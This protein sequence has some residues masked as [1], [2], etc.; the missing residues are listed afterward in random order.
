MLLWPLTGNSQNIQFH[1][2]NQ[3]F[4]I[5]IRET[6]EVCSDY[7]GFIWVSSKLGIIRLTEEDYR[8]YLL[9]Y[10][11]G[12]VINVKLVYRNMKLYAYTN[13]GQIF[14]YDP[15]YDRF[16]L[17][18][19]MS[20]E[21]NNQYLS[22]NTILL[23][24]FNVLWIATSDGLYRY[25]KGQLSLDENHS[26]EV[27]FIEWYGNDKI[28]IAEDSGLIIY[29]LLTADDESVCSKKSSENFTVCKLF[30]DQDSNRLW[31]GTLFS[32]LFYLD[33]GTEPKSIV[34]VPE[35][36]R[37]PI[38]A[39]EPVSDNTI[40]VGI[41]GQGIWEIDSETGEII[42]S[43]KENPDDPSSL[44]GNGVYDIYCDQNRRVWVCTYSGG[45]SFFDQK[46]P[47]I[48]QYRHLI[49]N[50]NSLVNNDVNYVLED[51]EGKLWFATNNGISCY[52]SALNIWRTYNHNKMERAQVFTN[53]CE[54]DGKI[55][56][57]TYSS[58]VYLLDRKTGKELAHYFTSEPGSGGVSNFVFS[59]YKDDEGDIWIGGVQGNLACFLQKEGIF[60]S[61]AYLP[62]NVLNESEP[63]KI[64]AGCTY[65]LVQIDKV[66]GETENLVEGY[67]V[68]DVLV[69]GEYIWLCTSGDGLIR[70]NPL[71]GEIKKFT[72]DDGLLSDFVNSA[73]Y[74][75]GY[76]WLG[77]ESG[78]CRLD[79]GSGSVVIFPS[80]LTLSNISF[81][82]NAHFILKNGDLIWGTNNGA[83]QFNPELIQDIRPVGK[84]FFQDVII[85]GSSL[86]DIPDFKPDSPLDS[87]VE[88]S[89]RHNQNTI[90][91]ELLSLG[92]STMGS[93]FSWQ[94]EG[95][96][97]SW[98][99][100]SN[101]RTISYANL[102]S[103]DF[104]LKIRMY[105]SALSQILD[106]REIFL[107]I[108]PPFW[109]KVW[110]KIGLLL[111][112][113]GIIGFAFTE[114]ISRLNKHHADQK[115]RFFSQMAHDMRTSVTLINSPVEELNKETKLSDTGRYFLNLA[116]E[117][118][119]RLASVV[120]QLMDFQK[121]DIGK[122]ILSLAMTDIVRVIQ[123]R[124]LMFQ[125]LAE[126]NNIKLNFKSNRSKYL[127]AI[128]EGKIEKVTDNL[129]SNAIKYSKPDSEVTIEI[130]C[131]ESR[132][133]LRVE[134]RGIGISRKSQRKMFNEFYRGENA[135]NAKIVGSGIGL[136][137]ARNYVVLH[138]GKISC[139]SQENVGSV[140]QVV[141]P[142]KKVK[143]DREAE[144]TERKDESASE[145]V[146]LE[147]SEPD[148]FEELNGE[149]YKILVVDDH[150]ELRNYMKTTLGQD[151]TV[152]TAGDGNEGWKSVL[153][154]APDIVISDIIMFGMD[155][156]ELCRILKS[157]YDT[158]HIPV[159]LLTSL[160]GKAEELHGLGLGADDYLTKPFDIKLL[161]QKIKTIIHNRSV[162]RE[163]ALK[164]IR[165]DDR[166]PVLANELNDRFVK[167]MVEVV[168]M[169]ISNPEF[170][171]E[172]FA[173]E[174][175]VSSSL[176]YK[177]AKSLTDQSPTD[178]LKA[179][180]M[181]HALRLIKE[182]KYN[183]TEISIMCGFSSV[184]YFSTVFKN[185]YRKSPSEVLDS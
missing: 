104:I 86:R 27:Q 44:Q 170:G 134:D 77:T 3:K 71:T 54:D 143:D 183:I 155:G 41:D 174:M 70:F 40:M 154:H 124:V 37:Q 51:K 125:Y 120:T 72:V 128:D 48:R 74:T 118:S 172:N 49:N 111:F 149:K 92:T 25:E 162:I 9:P 19:N 101:N 2:L 141:I 28:W 50:P 79:P 22:L 119:R 16:F 131:T 42:A 4:G 176:L 56:A 39:I 123:N 132:W 13:N 161:K 81:N 165:C 17:K 98:N 29:N 122:E 117:Q 148:T 175:N 164:L 32:G 64:L 11:S 57:G 99:N 139:S 68:H 144:K 159:I 83:V 47:L 21:L 171:K 133:T 107:Q 7:N 67:L 12:D 140:F 110:F 35:I 60:R 106:E 14:I 36:P 38:L 87:I 156:F 15:V 115:I 55:W 24:D 18:I 53:L 116:I 84:I 179:V 96:E 100:P 65:G 91:V 146:S 151:Y 31:A 33:P 167:K 109:D 46:T 75:N 69:V 142:Y 82:R 89:L 97:N 88:L 166:V 153:K 150:E 127:T 129:I 78:L 80:E 177:K 10:A 103:G 178:F 114:Y 182:K 43:Y 138:G 163:K 121:V 5:S 30:Y 145:I 130:T 23:D 135:V 6:N 180:R 1:N 73:T 137:L 136:V 52:D 173:Y 63:G 58:G 157:T 20:R 61:Y 108:N 112:I 95:L 85:S 105:D 181:D 26:S 158:S 76:L 62:V 126:S 34:H 45:V 168:K 185:Y 147:S 160:S 102:P 59:I 152:I 93:K 90:T 8:I 66:T 169:N 94:M 184:G 113:I